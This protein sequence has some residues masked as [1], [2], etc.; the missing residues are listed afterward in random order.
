MVRGFL[1]WRGRAPGVCSVKVCDIQKQ[2]IP[3]V[4]QAR[5]FK[6]TGVTYEL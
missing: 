2:G 1:Q 3:A 4:L 5:A 6:I